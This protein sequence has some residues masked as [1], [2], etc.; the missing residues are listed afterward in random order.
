MAGT[1]AAKRNSRSTDTIHN[2]G[3]LL[4]LRLFIFL[5]LDFN[6]PPVR[7]RGLRGRN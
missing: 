1:E 7:A 6:K 4:N 2:S 5:L 3:T